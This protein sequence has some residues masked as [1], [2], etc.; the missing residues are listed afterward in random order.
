MTIASSSN[1]EVL[2][3]FVLGVTGHMDVPESHHDLVKARIGR[4]LEWLRAPAECSFE[5][6]GRSDGVPLCGLGLRHTPIIV[7]TSLAPGADSLVAEVALDSAAAATL[8]D[9]KTPAFRVR[10]PIPFP[11]DVYR[12]STTFKPAGATKEATAR[13][14]ERLVDLL[15][16]IPKQDVFLVLT[17]DDW[18]ADSGVAVPSD[19]DLRLRFQADVLDPYRRHR[20]YAAA[21]EYIAAYSDLL[22]AVWDGKTDDQSDS[23][24]AAIVKRKLEGLTPGLLA[25][26]NAFKWA[27]TGPVLHMPLESRAG[28]QRG[29]SA[30]PAESLTAGGLIFPPSVGANASPELFP[31][32]PVASTSSSS[33]SKR[34]FDARVGCLEGFHRDFDALRESRQR[35]DDELKKLLGTA[36]DSGT[37]S[38][39]VARLH[40]GLDPLARLRWRASLLAGKCDGERQRLMRRLCWLIVGATVTLH[41]YA[42]W[43]PEHTPTP[44]WLEVSLLLSAIFSSTAAIMLY[45]RYQHAAT[46]QRR[47]D[48]RALCEGVRVQFHWNRAGVGRSAAAH[49]MQRQRGEMD[50]IRSALASLSIPYQDSAR[51]FR[52][53]T[54]FEQAEALSRVTSTWVQGQWEYYRKE[55]RRAQS[56]HHLFHALGWGSALAGL[57]HLVLLLAWRLSAGASAATVT[58]ASVCAL[59]CYGWLRWRVDLPT[60]TVESEGGRWRH[61]MSTVFSQPSLGQVAALVLAV[62]APMPL[63]LASLPGPV[64][65]LADL[66]IIVLGIVLAAGAVLIAWGEKSLYAEHARQYE[67]MEGLFGSAYRQLQGDLRDIEQSMNATPAVASAR[68]AQVQTLLFSLGKEALDEHAEWLILHRARPLEPFVAG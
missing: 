50:W 36:Q 55:G 19:V 57:A 2:P 61:I 42:H 62:T 25:V 45:A 13:N 32:R 5:D 48:Y 30:A 68:I 28:Q 58:I 21:G 46:E 49:Y 53:L 64:P 65:G 43:H 37:V 60:V 9:G 16:R 12:E 44:H 18:A 17:R 54:L 56:S 23:G 3:A 47:Y 24:T 29:V 38:S 10:A 35:E 1:K 39:D 11:L 6:I 31:A 51:E 27:N 40:Q 7:L 33:A 59:L 66:W 63:A 4:V 34:A 22:V 15:A 41:L 52:R 26:T 14:L 20:R 8:P 67:S